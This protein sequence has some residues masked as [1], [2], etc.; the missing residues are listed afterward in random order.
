[1]NVALIDD[2]ARSGFTDA[3]AFFVGF[4]AIGVAFT[5]SIDERIAITMQRVEI[6]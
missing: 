4:K 1:M 2:G 5:A 6:P 3:D